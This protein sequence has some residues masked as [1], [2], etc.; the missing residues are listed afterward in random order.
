MA[1]PGQEQERHAGNHQR[2]EQ[3]DLSTHGEVRHGS[4]CHI[5]VQDSR[6][7]SSKKGRCLENL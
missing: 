5:V 4:K 3:D 7:M 1:L 6:N 2:G